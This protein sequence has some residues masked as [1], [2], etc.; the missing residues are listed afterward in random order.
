MGQESERKSFLGWPGS[1]MKEG[2][3]LLEKE[4]CRVSQAQIGTPSPNPAENEP[5]AGS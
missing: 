1:R 2:L 4:G 3:G 5:T